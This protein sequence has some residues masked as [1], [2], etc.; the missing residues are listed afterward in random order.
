[1]TVMDELR[2]I[3][4]WANKLG[5]LVPEELISELDRNNE[6]RKP[7][8]ENFVIY[9]QRAVLK[10]DS[11]DLINALKDWIAGVEDDPETEIVEIYQGYKKVRDYKIIKTVKFEL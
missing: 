9:R 1:M 10:L 2:Y 4:E 7:L 3:G 8:Y 11:F 5:K 6:L